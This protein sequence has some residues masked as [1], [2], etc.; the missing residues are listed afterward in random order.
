MMFNKGACVLPTIP[1]D[2]LAS[3]LME[4]NSSYSDD[5]IRQ[6]ADTFISY[7]GKVF[8]SYGSRAEKP[9]LRGCCFVQPCHTSMIY[10]LLLP[11]NVLRE[12]TI[13]IGA[14]IN[15]DCRRR[16][17]YISWLARNWFGESFPEGKITEMVDRMP[18][19][20][21]TVKA[22]LQNMENSAGYVE[23][24]YLLYTDHWPYPIPVS[25]V[26]GYRGISI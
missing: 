5:F 22:T 12:G 25:Y 1:A 16:E 13:W 3:V 14:H 19:P 2:D 20:L 11:A 10:G 24:A 7:G 23:P 26:D 17:N 4:Y 9:L 6:W 8:I 21:T 18:Q 15:L